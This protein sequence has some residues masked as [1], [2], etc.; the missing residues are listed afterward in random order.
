MTQTR[1]ALKQ[2]FLHQAGL[3]DAER[4]PLPGDAS[5]RRYERLIR[6]DGTSL[7]LM[8]QAPALESAPCL[9]EASDA[10]RAVSGYNASARLAAGRI[11]AFVATA[12]YLSDHGL[13]A[14]KTYDLDTANG[15]LIHED[16][17]DGL[18]ARLIAEGENETPLYLAAIGVQA[19]LHELTPPAVLTGGWPLLSYDDLALKTG[20][21][22]FIE[23]WP[24]F[25]ASAP[26]S[27][28][29]KA[30]WEGLWA[31]LRQRAEAEA[32]VFIHRDFHA[33]NL[34]W[35]GERSGVARVGLIDFQDALKAHPSWDLHSLLQDARRDVSPELEALCLDYYFSL[36]PDLD[37]EGFMANYAALAALNEARIL[38]VFARLIKRDG[39]PRYEAFMPRMWQH[40]SRNLKAPGMEGLHQWFVAN[41]FGDKLK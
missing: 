14:P 7:M 3:S 2:D 21:D 28:Q 40:L 6:A 29:A 36:R 17:G 20:A 41:G 31:P 33:E 5:T 39:K 24:Q 8:D 35:L 23:W 9:P 32:S 10:E 34:L 12:N 30:D 11:E 16:L 19:R 22:L 38:G 37:R 26:L 27:D 25:D 4:H 1:E 18:F 13:S 15:F